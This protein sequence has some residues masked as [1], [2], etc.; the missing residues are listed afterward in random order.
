[1]PYYYKKK[2]IKRKIFTKRNIKLYFGLTVLCF[3]IAAA[4]SF[5][6]GQVPT[7]VR[8]KVDNALIAEAERTLGRKLKSS[9]LDLIEKTIGVKIDPSAL[10]GGSGAYGSG[11]TNDDLIQRAKEAYKRGEIDDD[12]INRVKKV[13][14]GKL[15]SRDIKKARKAYNTG[16]ID[17]RDMERAKQAYKDGM[18][19]R[20]GV[21]EAK[22]AFNKR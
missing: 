8:Q 9:D 22:K 2:K 14:K 4:L 5:I 13:Y 17:T 11:A 3:L 15:S 1:M 18:I 7:F 6:T 12:F 20:E 19:S 10:K 16:K 21:E